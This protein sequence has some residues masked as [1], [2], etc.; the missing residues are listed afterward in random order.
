MTVNL[1]ELLEIEPS[2][3]LETIRRSY[4]K[5]ALKWHPDK[6]PSKEAA[7]KF[8]EAR[9]AF[10]ILSHPLR[11]KV[12]DTGACDSVDDLLKNPRYECTD[13]NAND[14]ESKD[15]RAHWYTTVNSDFMNKINETLYSTQA[16]SFS[17]IEDI[18][19]MHQTFSPSPT[20]AKFAPTPSFTAAFDTSHQFEH[21]EGRTF[22]QHSKP[23][24]Y[25]PHIFR[26]STK[27]DLNS[28]SHNSAKNHNNPMS[29]SECST[30]S[31]ATSSSSSP[32][33]SPPSPFSNS[34]YDHQPQTVYASPP[35][36]F[37]VIQKVLPVG[38]EELYSGFTQRMKT[39]RMV[40]YTPGYCFEEPI[41]LT[42]T[43]KPG[44][45]SG[46][47]FNFAGAGDIPYNSEPLPAQVIL[48]EKPHPVYRRERADLHVDLQVSVSA[49]AL[50]RTAQVT[51]L[52]GQPY[53]FSVDNL[54]QD[55][56]IKVPGLGM[57]ICHDSSN[58]SG[59]VRDHRVEPSEVQHGALIIHVQVLVPDIV[60]RT[61]F[62]QPKGEQNIHDGTCKEEQTTSSRFARDLGRPNA[63]CEKNL[64]PS[65][66]CQTLLHSSDIDSSAEQQR[67][68]Y[69][70]KTSSNLD[71]KGDAGFFR[72]EMFSEKSYEL[73]CNAA[74]SYN[75]QICAFYLI[76]C[77]HMCLDLPAGIAMR[78]GNFFSL[79]LLLCAG[80]SSP[81][82]DGVE[83]ALRQ[84]AQHCSS[85]IAGAI[86]E[87]LAEDEHMVSAMA[88]LPTAWRAVYEHVCFNGDCDTAYL[89]LTHENVGPE[90]CSAVS[91]HAA[92]LVLLAECCARNNVQ[93]TQELLKS[94]IVSNV[95]SSNKIGTCPLM[96][97]ITLNHEDIV[98]ILL[99][100]GADPNIPCS[101][102][103][104]SCFMSRRNFFSLTNFPSLSKINPALTST[105][106]TLSQEMEHGIIYSSNVSS[107][108]MSTS[109]ISYDMTSKNCKICR[110]SVD[111]RPVSPLHAAVQYSQPRITA[112]LLKAG[113]RVDWCSPF[114]NQT[115]LHRACRYGNKQAAQLLIA[116]GARTNPIDR[117]S[118]NP[119][120]LAVVY[121]HGDII[122]AI[123]P[124][125][126][127]EALLSMQGLTIMKLLYEHMEQWPLQARCNNQCL[128][129]ATTY[130]LMNDDQLRSKVTVLESSLRVLCSYSLIGKGIITQ[131]SSVTESTAPSQLISSKA[132]PLNQLS[133]TSRK[134]FFRLRAGDGDEYVSPL[135]HQAVT[136]AISKFEV[137][138]AA[139]DTPS[140]S[141][142]S[143]SDV[144]NCLIDTGVRLKAFIQCQ[145][146]VRAD[147]HYLQSNVR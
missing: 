147:L 119:V 3:N 133:I 106:R 112:L 10:E 2:A 29:R 126:A 7:D 75:Y 53:V 40:E 31:P 124:A 13:L 99:K 16:R 25:S 64:N 141:S 143:G 20:F 4:H 56:I 68:P 69:L 97:A 59:A 86:R 100:E 47:C 123:A 114:D 139:R 144:L 128:E 51:L 23:R 1:Y 6:N 24:N 138:W 19:H 39:V 111:M 45:E 135:L 103:C 60:T 110:H 101:P 8:N 65:T 5:L 35:E 28:Y 117:A 121:G 82:P 91:S 63:Y 96:I 79:V 80:S 87:I 48:K 72:Q 14:F 54:D 89:L 107:L 37:Q 88:R 122:N 44:L 76:F 38:L 57:P 34:R 131:T 134:N 74:K 104:R 108:K 61:L 146:A 145:I 32:S 36:G 30:K 92:S 12:Y 42:I 41:V 52:E 105:S 17:T 15:I 94:S 137:W 83:A 78:N 125:L 9:Q 77:R 109:E 81:H 18:F 11:R 132:S 113:A 71:C 62:P 127:Q 130:M 26:N 129:N 33:S 70:T 95:S 90:R 66:P 85:P 55:S 22:P 136:R 58:I 50:G 43:C 118:A 93:C 84:A 142:K 140:L 116:A 21:Q 120:D 73:L 46:T 67:F 102:Y 98:E 49:A 27:P 115:A